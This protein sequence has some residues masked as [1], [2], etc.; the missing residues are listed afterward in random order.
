MSKSVI[1]RVSTLFSER[2][3]VIQPPSHHPNHD[4]T[5]GTV[6]MTALDEFIDREIS[7]R[8]AKT[9]TWK[10]LE[11]CFKWARI[12]EYLTDNAVVADNPI[13]ARLYG[14]LKANQLVN[15][16]YNARERKILK[17]NAEDL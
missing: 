12:Q 4:E 9:V 14:M 15:V 17:L 7:M 3:E 5:K 13:V 1:D 2:A 10:N 11:T 16:Q 6:A 8:M